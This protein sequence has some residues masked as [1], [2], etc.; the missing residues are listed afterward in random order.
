MN[1][2]NG[3]AFSYFDI[4][5][6][7]SRYFSSVFV[8]SNPVY[9]KSSSRLATNNYVCAPSITADDI[10]KKVQALSKQGIGPDMIPVIFIKE[11]MDNLLTPLQMIF[12]KSLGEGAFPRIWKTAAV[13]PIFKSGNRSF[14]ASYRPVSKLCIFAK[15]F[16]SIIY[17]HILFHVK[18]LICP[19]QHG[20]MSGRSVVSNL[21]VYT[22]FLLQQMDNQQQVDSI[23]T[24]FSKA[25]DKI[26][27]FIMLNKLEDIGVCDSLLAWFESYLFD[28]SQFVKIGRVK[29]DQVEITS[30]VPQGSHLGPL[31]FNIY[32]N[33]ISNCFKHSNFL[34]Y[35]DDLKIYRC[36]SSIDNC[37]LL[38]E[39]IER[40]KSYCQSNSLF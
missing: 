26:D 23:Y 13:S 19:S 24:D 11:C 3:A 28:R 4:S 22:E 7:F 1:D 16:E 18:F 40:L 17:D 15:I 9:R 14:V 39:D 37:K 32:I 35:A 21:F 33:D 20:F 10:T 30:G 6:C 36:V 38:Q 29:S 5:Q 34:M 31:L 2:C 8:D 12:N 25:F 27:H